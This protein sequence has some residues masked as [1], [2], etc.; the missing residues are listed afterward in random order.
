[1]RS[2]FHLKNYSLQFFPQT[3]TLKMKH[4]AYNHNLYVI[5]KVMSQARSY[6]FISRSSAPDRMSGMKYSA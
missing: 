2:F 6:R 5:R 4:C 3:K 1:M